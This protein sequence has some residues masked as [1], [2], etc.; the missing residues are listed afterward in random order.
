MVNVLYSEHQEVLLQLIR[1]GVDF[2]LIGGYAVIAHGYERTTGDMDL[3]IRPDNS[4]KLLLVEALSELGF[5]KP[6]LDVIA[7]SDFTQPFVF[8]IGEEPL[9]IDFLTK[10]SGVQYEE[11]NA[12]KVIVEID[13]IQL[14][15]LHLNHLVLSKFVT[16]R[17]KDKAD[18]DELQRIERIA[19][20][21]P[22]G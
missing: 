1:K 11:A 10:I 22:A 18:I 7:S 15:V 9:K 8:S 19:K 6:D 4:N 20:N 21:N 17:L 12:Q 5:E 2:I 13:G 14:P 3:W 16:G